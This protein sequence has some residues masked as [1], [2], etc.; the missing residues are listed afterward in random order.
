M[1]IC[2]RWTG[3]S[4]NALLEAFDGTGVT[5]LCMLSERRGDIIRDML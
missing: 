2:R 5:I 1:I 4:G 3:N